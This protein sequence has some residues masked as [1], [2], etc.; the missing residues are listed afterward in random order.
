MNQRTLGDLRAS[1]SRVAGIEPLAGRFREW[2][3]ARLRTST[4]LATTLA[5][6]L[7]IEPL[8]PRLLL[9]ADAPPVEGRIDVAGEADS[10]IVKIST[11][12]KYVFD[13]LTDSAAISWNLADPS[14]QVIANRTFGASDARDFTGAP[15]LDLAIG[16]YTLSIDGSADATGN[17]AF[18]LLDLAD[19]KPLTLGERIAANNPGKQTDLYSFD[20]TAGQ[21]FYFDAQSLTGGDASWRLL[22]P[23]GEQVRAPANISD[24]GVFSLGR[25]GKYTLSLEARDSNA[26]AIDYAFTLSRVTQQIAPLVLGQTLVGEIDLA[27][28]TDSYDFTLAANARVVFDTLLNSGLRWTLTGPRGQV[29]ANRSLASSDTNG[30]DPVLD[31]VAGSY[32]LTIAG[33]S[34]AKGTYAFRLLDAASALPTAYGTSISATIGNGEFSAQRPRGAGAPLVGSSAA[35]R[36]WVVERIADLTVADTAVHRPEQITVEAWLLG[37]GADFYEG[38]VTKISD[39]S[40][41]DGY[42][43]V[44]TGDTVRFFVNS[45]SGS[46]VEFAVDGSE[47]HHVAGTYDG[48]ALKLYVDGV[49]VA[50][51]AYAEAIRHTTNALSFGGAPGGDYRWNGSI[52]EARLWNV[53]RTAEQIA[54]TWQ[55]PLSGSE[56]GLI[57]YWPFD[58][59]SGSVAAD[60][61]PTAAMATLRSPPGT[62]TRIYSF[63]ASKGERVYLDV[64]SYAGAGVYARVL[65]PAGRQIFA[66]TFLGD[67]DLASLPMDGTYTLL[68]EGYPYN[69]QSVQFSAVLH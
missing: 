15:V 69:E 63:A 56:T 66:S 27:G 12:S 22:G 2:Q 67:I 39:A 10:F 44:R 32:R 46:F 47:W 11:P 45:W 6:R 33:D 16:E 52:D 28:N 8:E 13:S 19:A 57:G 36:S 62:E 14:G 30:G 37:N 25:T 59:E 53:A 5:N 58:E 64:L 23:D 55:V 4:T 41:G 35:N 38:A 9:S 42:G 54:A 17:Y 60:L 48:A 26:T 21:S 18:R 7:T 40:W 61:S 31:L 34:D 65:D 20:V 24:S 3:R 43:L 51:R 1:L 29:V 50:E 68:I 49:M